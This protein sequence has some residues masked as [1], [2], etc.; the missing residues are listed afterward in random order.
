MTLV[1]SSPIVPSPI[2]LPLK[3]SSERS[4]GIR[5]G[6]VNV[7]VEKRSVLL[8]SA[9]RR[10]SRVRPVGEV[11]GMLPDTSAFFVTD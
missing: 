10:E 7:A 4:N 3:T 2:Q 5:E 9:W 6:Q 11:P 1:A 8:S